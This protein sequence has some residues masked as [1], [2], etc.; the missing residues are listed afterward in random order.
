MTV[1]LG[2]LKSNIKVRHDIPEFLTANFFFD[3]CSCI[4]HRLELKYLLFTQ[5]LLNAHQAENYELL[6]KTEKSAN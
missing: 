1:V 3:T 4:G 5:V 2:L 6:Q